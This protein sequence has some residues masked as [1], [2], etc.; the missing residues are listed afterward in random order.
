VNAIS[1]YFNYFLTLAAL[2]FVLSDIVAPL[3]KISILH[4]ITY[5]LLKFDTN[6]SWRISYMRIDVR[7]WVIYVL[8]FLSMILYVSFLII[9]ELDDS[10][11][12]LSVSALY[13]SISRVYE[14]VIMCIL[15]RSMN[16]YNILL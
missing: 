6:V 12:T 11:G 14:V 15:P 8:Y 9:A 3:V 13:E 2:Y 10:L 7:P 5:A 4:C 16:S 1:L